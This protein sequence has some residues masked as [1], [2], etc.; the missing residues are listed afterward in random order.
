MP[1][2][3]LLL[4]FAASLLAHAGALLPGLLPAGGKPPPPALQ[5]RLRSLSP[6]VAEA[7]VKNTLEAE[8]EAPREP[9]SP[10]PRPPA[11]SPARPVPTPRSSEPPAPKAEA[12]ALRAA[13]RKLAEHTY[14]PPEAIA[15][16]LEGEARV[17]VVLGD[18]GSIADVQLA[19]SSGHALLDN[20]ALKA[21]WAIGRL[22]GAGVRQ[23]ILPVSFRL[24]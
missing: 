20:A 10:A 8:P 11:A 3:R 16:N 15:R 5:V 2:R 6:V 1:S 23:L 19:A 21:A 12:R 4:A 24:Q 9:E 18:D 17:I 7:L 13:Q 14:Y 22:P